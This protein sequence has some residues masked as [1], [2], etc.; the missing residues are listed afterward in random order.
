MNS[1]IPFFED[2]KHEFKMLKQI[3]M[4]M[5]SKY[6]C[7]FLNASGGAL[8]IGITDSGRVRGIKLTR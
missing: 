6:I 2:A 3:R 4:D 7:A 5:V 8:Y 1:T